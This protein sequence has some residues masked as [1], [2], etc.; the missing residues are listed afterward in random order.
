MCGIVGTAGFREPDHE[1]ACLA[2][3]RHRGPDGEGTFARE[4]LFLG[5]RRLAI[6][7][8]E[9][10]RQPATSEDGR[11]QVVYNGEVYNAP[12]IARE[13]EKK[14]YRLASGADTEILPHLYEEEGIEGFRRLEGMFAFALWDERER[15]LWLVRD[16]VGIKPLFW[17]EDGKGRLAF[18]S[19]LKALLCLDAVPRATDPDAAHLLLNLRYVPGERTILR[20]VRKLAPG[21]ALRWQDGRVHR[22][23]LQALD[24]ATEGKE[25]PDSG[26]RLREALKVAVR[27]QM[28]SDVPLGTFLSGGLDS[29]IVTTL[30]VRSDAPPRAA[31]TLAFG[32]PTDETSDARAVADA[33]GIPHRT[34][35]LVPD[36][37]RL[38][39]E[40]LWHTESPSVNAVQGYALARFAA[41]EVKVALSGLG[42]DELFKGY[43]IHRRLE[44]LRLA[45]AGGGLALAPL[46]RWIERAWRRWGGPLSEVPQRAVGM[47]GRTADPLGAYL[48]LRNAWEEVPALAGAIYSPEGAR[49]VTI[50]CREPFEPFFRG[51]RDPLLAAARTEFRTKM[52]DDFLV[53]ED[54]NSMAHGLEARVPFLDTAF[55]SAALAIPWEAR[56]A[57]EPKRL[58]REAARPLLPPSVL[59]K[60]KKGFANEPFFHLDRGLSKWWDVSLSRERIE[61]DGRFRSGFVDRIRSHRP[62]RRLRWHYF[63]LWL[64]AGLL[65]WEEMFVQPSPN[66]FRRRVL[67]RAGS[68][69]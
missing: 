57:G 60:P 53:N 15:A 58:L 47:A 7:D 17:W 65:D 11:I 37:D 25:A 41:S 26:E 42:A 35:T 40:V 8:P 4:N 43:E 20:G 10:G 56:F 62:D 9:H 14:G 33:C 49:A 54:R 51:E 52:V 27:R 30:A 16:P 66:E 29:S 21:A 5:M 44:M 59:A 68:G 6:L 45:R 2:A 50:R 22:S 13:L 61:R 3:I 69:P 23:N 38:I 39:P 18:A 24:D 32:E 67:A 36:L 63:L 19:E 55:L 31:F 12:Q 28:R 48:L 34:E 1:A 64:M 46:A